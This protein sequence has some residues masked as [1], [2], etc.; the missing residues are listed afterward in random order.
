MLSPTLAVDYAGNTR[1]HRISFWGLT[2]MTFQKSLFAVGLALV[3]LGKKQS[4]VA[5]IPVPEGLQPGDTYHLLINTSTFTNAL[6][7]SIEYYNNHVQ[8]A[9]D[10]AGIGS[11]E[12]VTW[13][14]IASTETIDAR[15]NAV[16]GAEVPVYNTRSAG[17]QKIADGFNDLWDGTIDSFPAYN[18]FGSFNGVDPWTGSTPNGLRATGSTLGDISGTAWCG[19]PTRLDGQWL[20]II[21]PSTTLS[22]T[23]YALSEELTV[24]DADFD[25]DGDVDGEDFLAWQRGTGDANG[26]EATNS[27][28]LGFWSQQY[29]RTA[30]GTS[31]TLAIASSVPEPSSI[32]LIIAVTIIA[33]AD[34]SRYL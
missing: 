4:T 21:Q 14:A 24:A 6:S 28:D 31:Q 7:S 27:V 23:V 13:K 19:R 1:F 8:T 17:M 25:S 3:V 26:D 12:G 30:N 33:A 10:F 15:V 20:T 16:V 9:A 18:E 34:R 29:G 5:D 11:S 2:P 22:L 32:V